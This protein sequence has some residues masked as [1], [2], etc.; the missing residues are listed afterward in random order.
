MGTLSEHAH[1]SP[2]TEP[3]AAKAA[4]EGAERVEQDIAATLASNRWR[5]HRAYRV[6]IGSPAGATNK[7]IA[8]SA[9]AISSQEE[10]DSAGE[11][12]GGA[13]EPLCRMATTAIPD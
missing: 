7:F 12:P 4:E 1:K 5:R 3:T 2:D 6:H 10:R 8:T 13:E 11:A 9:T